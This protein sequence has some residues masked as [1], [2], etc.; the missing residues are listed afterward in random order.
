M[1]PGRSSSVFKVSGHSSVVGGGTSVAENEGAI[2]QE[3][4]V[5][6]T[7]TVDQEDEEANSSG[8]TAV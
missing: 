5:T 2:E 1:D 8:R 6:R 7:S 4:E 3:M